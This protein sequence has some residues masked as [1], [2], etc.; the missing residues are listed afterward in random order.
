MGFQTSAPTDALE[1]VVF[2]VSWITF[3]IC[4]GAVAEA[5]AAET[6]NIDR[7]TK[8]IVNRAGDL[9]AASNG[10][11]TPCVELKGRMRRVGGTN[12]NQVNHAAVSIRSIQTALRTAHHFNL[13]NS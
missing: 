6:A 9:G 7:K 2:V 1:S 3:S 11:V 13:L 5:F 12:P 8:S 10:G 4:R